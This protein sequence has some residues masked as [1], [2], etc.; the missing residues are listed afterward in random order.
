MA[1]HHHESRDNLVPIITP[2]LAL[3]EFE[4]SD[5]AKVF[6]MSQERGMRTWIPDQVYADKDETRE[7]LRYLIAHYSEPGDP[8]RGPYVLGVCLRTTGELVGHVGLSPLCGTVEI[9]YAIEERHQGKGFASEAVTATSSW[10]LRRFGLTH[11]LGIAAADNVASCR[12]LERAGYELSQE[13]EGCLHAHR[14][15][16]RTYHRLR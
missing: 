5:V 11:I 6:T 15:L 9:G 2:R 13:V 4:L 1:T 8:A 12:V 16:I 7:L 10:A 3:R 14:G